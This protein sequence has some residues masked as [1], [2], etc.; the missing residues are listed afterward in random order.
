[1]KKVMLFC[2]GG[3][4]ALVAIASAGPV[5]GLALCAAIMYVSWKQYRQADSKAVKFFWGAAGVIAFFAA[6]GN[7]PALLGV[8]ALG[9]LYIVYKKWQEDDHV[10]VT[11]TKEDDPFV[12]FEKQ[13]N[14]LKK[15]NG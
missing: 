3:L 14:Q 13:W 2:I 12:N 7:V 4:A 6:V 5:L 9:V 8:A 10:S 11:E 1:M 15:L